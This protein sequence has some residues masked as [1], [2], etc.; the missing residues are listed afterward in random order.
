VKWLLYLDY[1]FIDSLF[2]FK[3]H[4]LEYL[5]ATG[6]E[7]FDGLMQRAAEPAQKR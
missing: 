7:D 6:E 3:S 5:K 1:T 4:Y 2:P